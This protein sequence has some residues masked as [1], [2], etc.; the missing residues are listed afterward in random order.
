[1]KFIND[2]A[3]VQRKIGMSKKNIKKITAI[4]QNSYN[5]SALTALSIFIIFHV[6]LCS[7]S[8]INSL[9]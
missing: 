8:V 6:V 4:R 5:Q 7:S 1:M 3:K 9:Y 2:M